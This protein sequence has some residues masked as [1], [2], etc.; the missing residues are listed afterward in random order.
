MHKCETDSPPP[1]KTLSL[2]NYCLSKKQ[3]WKATKRPNITD[4]VISTRLFSV[5]NH[6]ITVIIHK[7]KEK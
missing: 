4:F 1:P 2:N 6:Y 3:F 5:N 7:L